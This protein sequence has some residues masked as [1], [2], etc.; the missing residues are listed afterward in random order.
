MSIL[1]MIDA[2]TVMS[3][4]GAQLLAALENGVCQYPR[5]EGRFPQ[6][7]GLSFGFNPRQPAGQRV[8]GPVEVNGSPLELERVSTCGY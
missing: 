5:L 6:V 2:L 8:T 1:P 4:S 7:S 3:I